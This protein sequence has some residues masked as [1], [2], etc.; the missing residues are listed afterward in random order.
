MSEHKVS[1]VAVLNDRTMVGSISGTSFHLSLKACHAENLS[2][3]KTASD[4]RGITTPKTFKL[5]KLPNMDFIS[6]RRVLC[7]IALCSIFTIW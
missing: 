2:T 5:L 1:A 3:H 6:K 4:L 7:W